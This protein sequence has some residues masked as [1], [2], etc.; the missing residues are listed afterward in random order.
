MSTLKTTETSINKP[1]S[2]E[3]IEHP[4]V[5][6]APFTTSQLPLTQ[7]PT[8][9][10]PNDHP[11]NEKKRPGSLLLDQNPQAHKR[12]RPTTMNTPQ[13]QSSVSMIETPTGGFDLSTP[14]FESILKDLVGGNGAIFLQTPMDENARKNPQFGTF[15]IN[16]P[17]QLYPSN[18]FMNAVAAAAATNPATGASGA[19]SQAFGQLS[20]EVQAQMQSQ[21][22]QAQPT[23]VVMNNANTTNNTIAFFQAQ[24]SYPNTIIQL[25]PQ[26]QQQQHQQSQQQQQQQQP[27]MQMQ[28]QP[29]EIKLNTEPLQTVPVHVHNGL[30]V[31]GEAKSGAQV[32]K[33]RKNRKVSTKTQ[34]SS[35][36]PSSP[37]LTTASNSSF[38]NGTSHQFSP[39][40]LGMQ[41][42]MKLEKK[43]ERNREAAQKCRQRKLEKIAELQKEVQG[44][45]QDNDSISSE[46]AKLRK[47]IENLQRIVDEHKKSFGCELK[48][49]ENSENVYH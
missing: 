4:A 10:T 7:Q 46:S 32:A 14:L 2:S 40:D 3:T 25:K 27:Q 15:L 30:V 36:N 8:V 21:Q 24:S 18:P 42:D 1:N 31:N 28:L 39:I 22:Q 45:S 48:S 33:A 47:E 20:N 44:L 11:A 16:T 23:F 5:M 34:S 41:D 38:N 17:T 6:A 29:G 13:L 19:A 9:T 35:S 37:A 49:N 12:Q 43:R 26:Q